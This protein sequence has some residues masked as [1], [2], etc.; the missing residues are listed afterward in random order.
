MKKKLKQSKKP[1]KLDLG[2]GDNKREGFFGIDI[3]KT[4]STDMVADLFKF[5]W[6]FKDN[7]VDEVFAS[8]FFEHVPQKLRGKFMDEIYRILVPCEKENNQP[9]K[10]FCHF[11]VPYYSSMRAVQDFTHEWPPIAET[12]FLYFNKQWRI[13]NRLNHYP[14]TCD[15]DFFYGYSPDPILM[16]KNEELRTFAFKNYINAIQDLNITLMKR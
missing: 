5:P 1:L 8:H 7:S 13:D 15:F 4:K 14:V 9:I 16:T 10:G 2:C 3:A 11:I 12:S 6:P